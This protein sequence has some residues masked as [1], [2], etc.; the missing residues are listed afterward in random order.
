VAVAP[1]ELL[2]IRNGGAATFDR[3]AQDPTTL[4]EALGVARL[5]TVARR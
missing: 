2:Q 5:E 1:D 3:G 4:A